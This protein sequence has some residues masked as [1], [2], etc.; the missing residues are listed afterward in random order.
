MAFTPETKNILCEIT[1]KKKKSGNLLTL[2]TLICEIYHAKN[3]FERFVE[4]KISMQ[5][6]VTWFRSVEHFHLQA[7]LCKQLLFK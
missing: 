4:M 1:E 3:L 2:I 5:I 6:F 7:S